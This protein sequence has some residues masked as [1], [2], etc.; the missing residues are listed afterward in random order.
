M[1]TLL[2]LL[3]L[4]PTL[5]LGQNYY[6]SSRPGATMDATWDSVAGK[7]RWSDTTI[8]RT[9]SDYRYLKNADSTT[10]RTASDYRYLKSTDSSG[11]A[12]RTFVTNYADLKALLT[13]THSESQ[14]TNLLTHQST[15]SDSIKA[16]ADTNVILRQNMTNVIAK[17][18][19][20]DTVVLV[21]WSVGYADV[22]DTVYFSTEYIYGSFYNKGGDTLIITSVQSVVQG[23]GATCT[24]DIMWN[25]SLIIT[26]NAATHLISTPPTANSTT[27]GAEV[28][29]FTNARIP[30]NVH[31]FMKTP[32][33]TSGLKPTHLSVT[34]SGYRKHS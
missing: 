21:V 22:G 5:L 16:V 18:N 2:A 17:S 34:M 9:A 20:I 24:Y 1:K 23:T 10:F 19:V 11:M 29:S 6:T 15:Q 30:P 8:F 33:I 25:D 12:T 27:L 31:V 13:H 32:T 28:T 3:L 14:V 7:L 4:V 26:G